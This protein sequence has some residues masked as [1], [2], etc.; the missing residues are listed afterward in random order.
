MKLSVAVYSRKRLYV[1][2][3]TAWIIKEK[4]NLCNITCYQ[5]M[6]DHPIYIKK[7]KNLKYR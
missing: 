3:Y 2:K 1:R 6:T 4:H 5:T 7:A